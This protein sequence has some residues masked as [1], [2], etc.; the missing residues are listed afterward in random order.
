MIQD[1]QEM[2]NPVFSDGRRLYPRMM[3]SNDFERRFTRLFREDE[4]LYILQ[5]PGLGYGL[6]N[7][8]K[9]QL[10]ESSRLLIFESDERLFPFSDATLD[11]ETLRGL[12]FHNSP[13]PPATKFRS[14]RRSWLDQLNE[15]SNREDISFCTAQNV[16]SQLLWLGRQLEFPSRIRRVRGIRFCTVPRSSAPGYESLIRE[17]EAIIQRHWQNHST[18]V[19]MAHLWIQNALRNLVHHPPA[20]RLEELNAM[21]PEG[22][23]VLCG[24]SPGLEAGIEEIRRLERENVYPIIAAVDTALPALL[25]SGIIPHVVFMLEAQFANMD[26]FICSGVRQA[27]NQR[28]SIVIHDLFCHPPSVRLFPRRMAYMSRFAETALFR[29]LPNDIPRI[30]PLGSVGVTALYVI[31]HYLK[32]R[33]VFISGLEFAF[34]P[35]KTHA[36]GT[37]AHLRALRT[38]DRFSPAAAWSRQIPMCKR[39]PRL[40]Q[41]DPRLFTTGVLESY[42]QRTSEII[43]LYGRGSD[44]G[45]LVAPLLPGRAGLPE[46]LHAAVPAGKPFSAGTVR[47][48][49]GISKDAR[50]PS[51]QSAGQTAA[52]QTAAGEPLA[53][54]HLAGELGKEISALSQKLHR[55]LKHRPPGQRGRSADHPEKNFSGTTAQGE[56]YEQF[57][58]SWNEILVDLENLDFVW[59]FLPGQPEPAYETGFLSALGKSMA[60]WIRMLKRLELSRGRTGSHGTYSRQTTIDPPE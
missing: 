36:K 15:L 21:F 59:K 32:D 60:Y 58:D 56:D 52:D 37:P 22:D 28:G 40:S 31:L 20:G 42:A 49:P 17:A 33:R 6:E 44:A 34:P 16:S 26:D 46:E 24:A 48:T 18:S 27:L 25:D 39:N 8:S 53:G 1:E 9:L 10:P 4:C 41:Q 13:A 12:L 30:P 45:P 7:L 38:A 35:G 29:R 2:P 19:H 23:V 55:L 5:S 54:T 51:G 43:Q 11:D 57:L 3:S 47:K 14:I 50:V